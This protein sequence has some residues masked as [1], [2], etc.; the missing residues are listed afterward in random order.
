MGPVGDLF[1]SMLYPAIVDVIGRKNTILLIAVPEIVSMS[2][3]H[4]SYYS[5][6][7]LYSARFIGGLSEAACFTIIPLYIGEVGVFR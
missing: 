4:F 3:I 2:M 1:G 6:M 7:L 5:K